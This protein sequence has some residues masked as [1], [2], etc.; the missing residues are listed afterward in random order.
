MLQLALSQLGWECHLVPLSAP[1][2]SG[3]ASQD[4]MLCWQPKTFCKVYGVA[5]FSQGSKCWGLLI[6]KHH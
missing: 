4:L 2:G 6:P 3:W 1:L 5:P